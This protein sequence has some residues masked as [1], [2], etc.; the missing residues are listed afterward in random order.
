[1]ARYKHY[2]YDQ[3][4]MVAVSLED[5]LVPGT[6]EYA[7]HHVI[8]DRLDTSRFDARFKNDETGR[9]AYDPKILLKIVL[10][11][12]A[13]GVMSSRKMER[14][15][16][17]NILY[18]ALSCGQSP[19]H[20]TLAAFVSTM[21]QEDVTDLF[22]QVLLV[23][24][25]EGLLGGTHMSIDGLKLPSNAAKEWSGTYSDLDKKKKKLEAKIKEAIQEHRE[26]DRKG[27]DRDGARRKQQMEKLQ[28]QADRIDRYLRES[29]PKIG[30]QGKEIQGNITDP[31]SAKM[32]SSHGV[33]Q[34]YNA[35]AV[36][37]EKHQVIVH[38]QAIG[39]GDDGVNAGPMLEGASR[40]LA[41]VLEKENPLQG[42]I[43]SADTSYFSL[44][45]L[46]ACQKHEVD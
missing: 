39:E 25:E 37:D 7:I 1:M 32:V 22:T 40:N 14:A 38:G 45:N 19:D 6:L 20:S 41:V 11:S 33:V 3:L 15:C 9:V 21:G 12:Y 8:E 4:Q 24:E 34:G 35:N 16:R 13:R 43:I 42:R 29:S 28:K 31:E 36:V 23:C 2:D 27:G 46:K 30:R 26:E 17:E 10:L 5:Q 18:M 44:E